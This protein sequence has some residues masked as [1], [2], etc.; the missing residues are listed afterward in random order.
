MKNK[1]AKG[2]GP[3]GKGS[4][5]GKVKSNGSGQNM[6]HKGGSKSAFGKQSFKGKC[7]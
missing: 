7:P 5:A 4:I 2:R 6:A 1:G 3:M